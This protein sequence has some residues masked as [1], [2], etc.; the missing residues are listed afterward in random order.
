MYRGK[1][2]CFRRKSRKEEALS[3]FWAYG[4][5]S[6]ILYDYVLRWIGPSYLVMNTLNYQAGWMDVSCSTAAVFCGLTELF[7]ADCNV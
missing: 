1:F 5:R 2:K 4:V 3:E 7:A 6:I